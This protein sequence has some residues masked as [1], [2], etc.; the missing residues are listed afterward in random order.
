VPKRM[1]SAQVI[2]LECCEAPLA[3]ASGA[4]GICQVC[5]LACVH[6]CL[7]HCLRLP[8]PLATPSGSSVC[9]ITHAPLFNGS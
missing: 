9:T 2:K 1:I 6:P 3:F 4:G 5:L 8:F 7:R